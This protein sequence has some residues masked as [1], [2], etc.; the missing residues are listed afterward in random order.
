VTLDDAGV[1]VVNGDA[2]KPNAI[3]V[4]ISKGKVVAS[5]GRA[6]LAVA[7]AK[8]LALKV[9]G[10]N[11]ADVIDVSPLVK[12][13]AWI[14]ARGGNDTIRTGGGNDT[15]I[16]GGGND[17]VTTRGGHD[18]VFDPVGKN[19][20]RATKRDTVYGGTGKSKVT[21]T[22]N[23]SLADANPVVPPPPDAPRQ[24]DQEPLQSGQGTGG[25]ASDVQQEPVQPPTTV[26]TG[27]QPPQQQGGS[28]DQEPP[29][30]VGGVDD[31]GGATGDGGGGGTTQPPAP[32]NDPGGID[33]TGGGGGGGDGT[34]QQQQ[35]P[36]VVT[37]VG[38]TLDARDFGAKLDGVTDDTAAIQ[39]ALDALPDTG[40]TLVIGGVAAI[41]ANGLH[42]QG[43]SHISIVGSATGAGFTLTA[44]PARQLIIAPANSV[45]A[46][47][48]CT[49]ATV[50]GLTINGNGLASVGIGM[51]GC[52][53]SSVDGN[54]VTGTGGGF[55]AIVSV[56]GLR[57]RY[58]GNYVHDTVDAC[59]GLW[60]GNVWQDEMDT[61]P[62]IEGNTVL[63]TSGSGIAGHNAGAVI[64]Q[65]VV[66]DTKGSGVTLGGFYNAVINY[67]AVTQD[68]LIEGNTLTGN[69]FQ[70]VQS[71]VFAGQEYTMR[72]TVVGN[73][74]A[75]NFN[76]GVYALRTEGWVI[77]DNT[78]QD[79]AV[80]IQLGRT[81]DAV[82]QGN[83]IT[84]T[85]QAGKRVQSDGISAV[86]NAGLA[87]NAQAVAAADPLVLRNIRIDGNTCTG[88]QMFGIHLDSQNGGVATDIQI[89]NNTCSG[90]TWD[91]LYVYAS[92]PGLMSDITY[93]G[94][95]C[96][97]NG[98]INQNVTLL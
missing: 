18:Q 96:T 64:R 75:D 9:T 89:T 77:R 60:I 26:D 40:G 46:L 39:A 34:Q 83:T 61:D 53:D 43:K 80:G 85:H 86:A 42:V 71:D 41:G 4:T 92:G 5:A 52:T 13:G 88:S 98:R 11:K 66:R 70:G 23:R 54:E 3:S 91:G 76:A 78:I 69:Y 93:A 51:R 84:S 82:I 31:G 65:N 17:R 48:N 7:V 6:K 22:S 81:Y 74:I 45:L 68:T 44:V 14:D 10:G 67:Y 73:F 16:G 90:N 63:R 94:N 35:P 49:D 37:T 59:R 62:L 29:P 2:A 25:T 79:N 20:V 47:L 19:V 97:G 8:V 30:V 50:H 38:P 57:N 36:P 32:T 55:G 15:V 33:L 58:V 87:G 56:G 12:L 24:Q 72:V 1:L 21:G 95:V 27:T 28:G